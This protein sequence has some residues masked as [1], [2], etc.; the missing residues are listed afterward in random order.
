MKKVVKIVVG[1][2]LGFLPALAF[3]ETFKPTYI[4]SLF[5]GGKQILDNAVVFLIA[6][7]VCWFIWNVIR[8]TIAED[9]EKKGE[10]K[11]QMIWGIIAIAVIVSIWGLVA[12]LQSIFGVEKKDANVI[13]DNFL[14][15]TLKK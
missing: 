9:E 10:A 5:T 11:N 14:P 13:P 3:A 12:L 7:A 1:S 4:N 15:T 2:V 6:L 8:Y